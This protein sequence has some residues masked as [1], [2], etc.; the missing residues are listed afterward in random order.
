MDRT[1]YSIIPQE[2][3]RNAVINSRIDRTGKARTETQRRDGNALTMAVSTDQRNNRTRLFIDTPDGDTLRFSGR[4]AR[5]L[6]RLLRKH[7]GFTSKSR[8]A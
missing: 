3:N 2:T 8:T 6:Y 5:S 4:E 7:Y 1:Y